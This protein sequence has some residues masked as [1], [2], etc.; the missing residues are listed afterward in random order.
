MINLYDDKERCSGCSACSSLCPKNAINMLPDEEGFLYPEINKEKCIECGLCIKI[1]PVNNVSIS[2]DKEESYVCRNSKEQERSISSSGGV[3]L[4]LA[5]SILEQGGVVCACGF[6]DEFC[7]VHK[8]VTD[9]Q[10]LLELVGSKYMQSR[11]DNCFKE[12]RNYLNVN[13]TVLFVGTTCQVE[14]LHAFLR[15]K[16]PNL[17]CVDLICKSVPSPMIWR[18]YLEL[19]FKGKSIK[20]INFKDKS[21]GWHKFSIKIDCQKDSYS[22]IGMFNEFFVGYF[23]GLY[24]RPFCSHCVFKERKRVSDITISDAWGIEKYY[25]EKDDNK[26]LSLVVIHSEKGNNLINKCRGQLL[27]DKVPFDM[28]IN[29]NKYGTIEMKNPERSKFWEDYNKFGRRFAFWRHC[30]AEDRRLYKRLFY[31]IKNT[32]CTKIKGI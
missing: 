15:T 30:V 17:Y 2:E 11:L 8:C 14:G 28:A 19:F 10:E 9:K 21:L 5:N 3:F 31:K 18:D 6:D 27:L 32:L 24:S 20:H 29:E 16:Y 1:C 25:P 23:K 22:E 4:A 26:G 12:I 13:R 7:A